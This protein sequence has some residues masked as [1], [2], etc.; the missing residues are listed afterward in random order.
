VPRSHDDPDE[1]KASLA[2]QIDELVTAGEA[3]ESFAESVRAADAATIWALGRDV[4][5]QSRDDGFGHELLRLTCPRLYLWSRATTPQPSQDFLHAQA[6]P[7]HELG[8]AHHWPWI[9]DP[10]A[11]AALISGP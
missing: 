9:V 6:V 8:I 1:F 3:P 10:V 4:V 7:H 5:L 11:V 2:T